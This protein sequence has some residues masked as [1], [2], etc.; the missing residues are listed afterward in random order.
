MVQTRTRTGCSMSEP[1][2]QSYFV[3][4]AGL[5]LNLKFLLK[6]CIPEPSI[7]SEDSNPP[8]TLGQDSDPGSVFISAE[9]GK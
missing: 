8:Q 9:E 1:G 7:Q 5:D 4:G 3:F 2:I 6:R